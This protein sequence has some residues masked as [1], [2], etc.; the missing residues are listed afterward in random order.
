MKEFWK[1][2]NGW[3]KYAIL[4]L[5]IGGALY[6]IGAIGALITDSDF[7]NHNLFSSRSTSTS[8]PMIGEISE[9][10]GNKDVAR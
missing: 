3:E 4:S 8:S 1:D 5:I 9:Y 7:I 2:L 10:I 6:L